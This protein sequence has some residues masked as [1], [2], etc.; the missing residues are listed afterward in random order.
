[1]F[2]LSGGVDGG[3]VGVG[4]RSQ[5]GVVLG[6]EHVEQSTVSTQRAQT[7]AG[8]GDVDDVCV[9][10]VCVETFGGGGGDVGCDGDVAEGVDLS[11]CG[12]QVIAAWDQVAAD[13]VGDALPPKRSLEQINTEV[14]H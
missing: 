11:G 1:M 5:H 4:V 6:A 10:R 13:D 9:Q 3:G 14:E 2:V 8:W 7:C 12:Q